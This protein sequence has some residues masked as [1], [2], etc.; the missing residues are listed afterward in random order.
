MGMVALAFTIWIITHRPRHK[1][2]LVAVA[3]MALMAVLFAATPFVHPVIL[4]TETPA[5]AVAQKDAM[6]TRAFTPQTLATALA[7][8]DPVFVYMTAAWCITCKVNEKVA[9]HAPE[10]MAYF[11]DNRIMSIVG[12]WTSRNPEIT[13]YLKD[14]GRS[15]VPLYV[16]YGPRDSVT[17]TRP[18]PVVLPQVLTPAIV[19]DTIKQKR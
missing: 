10:T 15:G 17:G 4:K 5:E 9:L 2:G 18:D 7:G 12:D 1:A 14:H 16:F 3:T 19:I 13:A 6:G 11:K 8:D